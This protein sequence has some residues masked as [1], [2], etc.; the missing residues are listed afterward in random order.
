MTIEIGD[1]VNVAIGPM[2]N[3]YAVSGFSGDPQRVTLVRKNSSGTYSTIHSD[4]NRVRHVARPVFKSGDKVLIDGC[5]AEFM[6]FE[7]G[8]EVARVMLAPRR[9]QFTGVGF[10][11]IGPAVVRLNYWMLVIENSKR[12]MEK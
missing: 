12:M 9:R 8:G 3:S 11:D 1:I 4:P 7:K 10:I 6:S 5:K 2:W